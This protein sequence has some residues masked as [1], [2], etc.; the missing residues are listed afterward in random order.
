MNIMTKIIIV[1]CLT[2]SQTGCS[3]N[4]GHRE[5]IV[6]LYN[7]FNIIADSIIFGSTFGTFF[8][9]TM[10]NF[11]SGLAWRFEFFDRLEGFGVVEMGEAG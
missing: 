8:Q 7:R 4:S 5:L 11:R 3:V 1:T 10:L 6:S 9:M 2:Q